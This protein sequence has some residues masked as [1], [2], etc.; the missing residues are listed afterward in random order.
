VKVLI[1]TDVL[2]DVALGRASSRVSGEVLR[3]A[4]AS[5]GRAAVAWHSL[6]NLAYLIRP[7]ARPFIREM[8]AFMDV[9]EV[10]TR[11][12]KAALSLPMHDLEDAMQA[13]AALAFG[14]EHVVTRNTRDYRNSPVPALNPRA[15]LRL[16]RAH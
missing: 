5:P 10:G 6:S 7:D 4:E 15:F 12:M 13:A 8:L 11:H 2:L 1:D 16:V 3:W 9:P 14:A